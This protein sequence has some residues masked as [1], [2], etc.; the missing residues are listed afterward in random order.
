MDKIEACYG[1]LCRLRQ[2]GGLPLMALFVASAH[3][4]TKGTT[5]AYFVAHNMVIN[6]NNYDE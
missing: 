5:A 3:F 6:I 1:T 2:N 4:V